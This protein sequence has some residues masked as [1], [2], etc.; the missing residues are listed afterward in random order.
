MAK[1]KRSKKEIQ[2]AK[3]NNAA[4]EI[5]KKRV[6]IIPVFLSCFLKK[7]FGGFFINSFELFIVKKDQVNSLKPPIQI[8]VIF[9]IVC[10]LKELTSVHPNHYLAKQFIF[11][12]L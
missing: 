11:F 9:I 5:R 2:R 1:S 6:L 12:A 10:H 7:E 4:S 3:V 8:V